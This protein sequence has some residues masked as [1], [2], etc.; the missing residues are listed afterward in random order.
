MDSFELSDRHVMEQQ[1]AKSKVLFIEDNE[2]MRDELVNFL[3][4]EGFDVVGLG[5]GLELNDYLKK[6]QPHILVLDLNLQF[7]DGISI[8]RRIRK[9]YP[10][11]RIVMLTGRVQGAHRL[12]GYEAGA[13]VYL[14]K[15]TRPA[16][17]LAV[18]KNLALRYRGEIQPNAAWKLD[19]SRYMLSSTHGH[20]TALTNSE[21]KLLRVLAVSTDVVNHGDLM[22]LFHDN[23]AD[24]KTI[25]ARLEVLIS[26][27]RAKLRVLG[28]ESPDIRVLRGLGYQ[29]TLPLS[30]VGY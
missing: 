25:K 29:L 15:P 2:T 16:E 24:E 4:A 6:D 9:S 8:A 27:L 12:E 11:I 3:R 30:I 26:R 1:L 22:A 14:T 17:I 21:M 7:E 10:E 13:D 18:L 28:S 19:V 5:D 23:M 20:V